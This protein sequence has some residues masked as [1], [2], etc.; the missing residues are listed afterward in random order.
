MDLDNEIL[1]VLWNSVIIYRNKCLENKDLAEQFKTD[2]NYK[3][4]EDYEYFIMLY[5][6]QSLTR[7]NKGVSLIYNKLV[8]NGID[9]KKANK[10]IYS[11]LK[12]NYKTDKRLWSFNEL[13]LFNIPMEMMGDRSSQYKFF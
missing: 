13:E 11:V 2:T 5:L 6:I 10:F 4:E 7:E 3:G 9:K 8:D 12:L 1:K